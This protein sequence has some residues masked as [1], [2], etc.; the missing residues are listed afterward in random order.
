MIASQP[1]AF[2]ANTHR[3]RRG[4][5]LSPPLPQTDRSRERAARTEPTR[6]IFR[7]RLRKKAH[8]SRIRVELKR[9][10][11]F[12]HAK[13]ARS[14]TGER[15]DC[16][17]DFPFSS[18]ACAVKPRKP[19]ETDFRQRLA[20]QVPLLLR[21]GIRVSPHGVGWEWKSSIL[22]VGGSGGGSGAQVS[23]IACARHEFVVGDLRARMRCGGENRLIFNTVAIAIVNLPFN[24][25]VIYMWK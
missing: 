8:A 1:G 6:A 5:K 9:R 14:G 20:P 24:I 13:K 23:K 22:L 2:C 17:P 7:L 25:I 10:G 11:Q 18:C 3:G 12:L 19:A 21:R 4:E 16:L 15:A